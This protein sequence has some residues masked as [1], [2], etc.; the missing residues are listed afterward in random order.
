MLTDVKQQE[1]D[2]AEEVAMKI[3]F[4]GTE[5]DAKTQ[6]LLKFL[7]I[8]INH[9]IKNFENL[10]RPLLKDNGL[11]DATLAKGLA[12]TKYPLLSNIIPNKDF[13]LVEVV[14]GFASTIKKILGR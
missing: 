8:D 14:E 11:V 2:I 4:G 13:R 1:M 6:W 3:F 10:V 12:A 5:L 7:D 9:Q